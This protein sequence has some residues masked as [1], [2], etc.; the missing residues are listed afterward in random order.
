METRVATSSRDTPNVKKEA[1]TTD[2]IKKLIDRYAREGASAN[3]LCIAALRSLGPAGYFRFN[4]LSNTQRN[5]IAFHDEFGR[6]IVS[7]S[8]RDI[9]KEGNFVDVSITRTN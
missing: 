6:I 7:D 1:S 9:Y 3:E 5:H 8:K 4:E 2:F